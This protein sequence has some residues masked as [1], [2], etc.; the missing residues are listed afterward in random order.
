MSRDAFHE[1]GHAEEELNAYEQSLALRHLSWSVGLETAG[2]L[3]KANG[4]A[5][6]L[7][8]LVRAQRRAGLQPMQD[9]NLSGLN[10]SEAQQ[11]A[12][13]KH[14]TQRDAFLDAARE[15]P[16]QTVPPRTVTFASDK[17]GPL[18]HATRPATQRA[19]GA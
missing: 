10:I 15:V 3:C 9:P 12:I 16:S 13:E 1:R 19:Q 4:G 14:R 18:D 2:E 11:E 5:Q 8:E 7:A 6:A 17:R